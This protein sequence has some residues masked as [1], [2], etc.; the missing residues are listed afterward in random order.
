ML[1][2]VLVFATYRG[3]ERT[4][5]AE[6]RHFGSPGIDS[7][8][9]PPQLLTRRVIREMRRYHCCPSGGRPLQCAPALLVLALTLASAAGATSAESLKNQRTGIWVKVVA[10]CKEAINAQIDKQAAHEQNCDCFASSADRQL[11]LH[12]LERIRARE[13]TGCELKG[14]DALIAALEGE[15]MG[16]RAKVTADRDQ[17]HRLGIRTVTDAFDTWSDLAADQERE[18]VKSSVLSTVSALCHVAREAQLVNKGFG[19]KRA[20]ET[21]KW[22]ASKGVTEPFLEDG[23]RAV[24]SS[25]GKAQLRAVADLAA[26]IDTG[27]VKGQTLSVRADHDPRR[28]RHCKA[29][30]SHRGRHYVGGECA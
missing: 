29:R 19:P 9:P 5:P 1:L 24:G 8:Q 22:L 23:I 7:P 28:A 14:Q 12:K 17:F 18:L 16:A 30:R 26:R 11:S 4:V 27:V 13:L 20:A 10:S 15:L 25:S 3:S 2:P 6:P 21:I